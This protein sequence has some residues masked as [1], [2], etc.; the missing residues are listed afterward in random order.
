MADSVINPSRSCR[1]ATTKGTTVHMTSP[2]LLKVDT[3]MQL[4][5]CSWKSAFE[6]ARQTSKSVSS[7]NFWQHTNKN[8]TF[9]TC[10]DFR[11][12]YSLIIIFHLF[13]MPDFT[14]CLIDRT[15]SAK[16][17]ITYGKR[18]YYVLHVNGLLAASSFYVTTTYF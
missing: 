10:L 9:L 4:Q 6:K 15:F 16:W 2:S 1:F 14:I 11:T 5:F 7:R 12:P 18:K 3:Y 17:I 8:I 13:N